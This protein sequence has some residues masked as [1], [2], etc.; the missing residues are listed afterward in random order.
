MEMARGLSLNRQ[1]L[2]NYRVRPIV[3]EVLSHPAY[4]TAV[5]KL[6]PTQSGMLP[7]ASGRGGPFNI[8]WEVH[9]SGDI[10]LVVRFAW[11]LVLPF[12]VESSMLIGHSG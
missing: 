12:V 5:W 3:E 9:G 2:I 6:K 7:V 4:P 1:E 10:K 8:C 11:F